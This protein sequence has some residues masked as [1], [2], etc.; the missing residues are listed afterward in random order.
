MKKIRK[1][2]KKFSA[3][4][5]GVTLLASGAAAQNLGDLPQPFVDDD[6][7]LASSIVIGEDAKTSDVVS[8]IDIATTLGNDAYSN[9]TQTVEGGETTSVNGVS[10]ENDI[11]STVSGTLTAT[12]FD[13]LV[14]N[15]EYGENDQ[16]VTEEVRVGQVNG[17]G[18]TVSTT[19]DEEGE[20]RTQVNS[21]AVEYN[22]DYQ[23]GLEQ[24]D[25][26]YLLGTEYELTGVSSDE[27]TLGSTRTTRNLGTGDT[28][29]HGPYTVEVTDNDG[30]DTVYLTIKE[31]GDTI[32]QETFTEGESSDTQSFGDNDEFEV[33]TPS[34]FFGNEERV[35]IETTYSDVTMTDGEEAPVDEDWIVDLG[36]SN[37]DTVD[38][39][40]LYNQVK[41]TAVDKDEEDYND[42]QVA[43]L[44]E[45][46]SLEGPNNFFTVESLGLTEE[47]STQLT[48]KDD[49]E[50]DFTDPNGIEH[51]LDWNNLYNGGSVS[52]GDEGF[53]AVSSDEGKVP[54]QYEVQTLNTGANDDE[55]AAE[56]HFSYG[57]YEETLEITGS[58][59][60]G[61]TVTSSNSGYGFPMSFDTGSETIGYGPG[62][63]YESSLHTEFGTEIAEGVF[64]DANGNEYQASILDSLVDGTITDLDSE[65][66]SSGDYVG[67]QDTNSNYL[68]VEIE[69]FTLGNSG[70]D[71][72]L[73]LESSY[74]QDTP[75]K[76][77]NTIDSAAASSSF[78]SGNY[79]DVTLGESNTDLQ[80]QIDDSGV[81][82]G[83][84]STSTLTTDGNTATSDT[85]NIAVTNTDDSTSQN[86]NFQQVT[87]EK[88][89]GGT[90][91]G[92]VDLGL[93]DTDSDSENELVVTI[94]PGSSN[95]VQA[96]I[97]LGGTGGTVLGEY[98][99][100]SSGTA[101]DVTVDLG[102]DTA[103][104]S[105]S[106]T[107]SSPSV[108][109]TGGATVSATA[110]GDA[111]KTG[112]TGGSGS[113]T[114]SVGQSVSVSTGATEVNDFS[115]NRNGQ[116]F[117]TQINS[118]SDSIQKTY[119]DDFSYTA[120]MISFVN[121]GEI[122]QEFH[123]NDAAAQVTDSDDNTLT[124]SSDVSGDL[125]FDNGNDRFSVS[126]DGD[127]DISSLLL[128]SGTGNSFT[129]SD[130]EDGASSLTTY[131]TSVDLVSEEQATFGIPQNQ[132]QAEHAVGEVSTSQGGD[133]SYNLIDPQGTSEVGVLDSEADTSQDLILVGGPDVNDLTEDLAEQGD[134]WTGDQYT[135]GEGLLQMVSDAFTSGYD[136]LVVAGQTAEDTT[137]AGNFLADYDENLE[138]LEGK[139]QVV[140]DSESGELVEE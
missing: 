5:L 7:E 98:E 19:V 86:Y 1:L 20:V 6:G 100:T 125:S 130:V 59:Y 95:P 71:R 28:V 75:S 84:P 30:E 24:G 139:S 65:Q 56:V 52:E 60:T 31:D 87:V 43:A 102:E 61:S 3:G 117:T 77:F 29:D 25:S 92:S 132:R 39:I 124:S 23:Q 101:S 10:L 83:T 15:Y 17:V 13:N 90:D 37:G 122:K 105:G 99:V 46:E 76:S 53:I 54:V 82:F 35:T 112:N 50:L 108:S 18:N 26:L 63:S 27:I 33:K 9:T 119:S 21:N 118:V 128:D 131:G 114:E 85:G 38:S 81:V 36:T 74:Q 55:T 140:V 41:A 69:T 127:N 103:F 111:S 68:P 129:L 48:V 94:T 8:A 62:A 78:N 96:T 70:N 2:S 12:S 110:S 44:S 109:V 107:T 97:Y 22:A 51:E 45:G 126:Y 47:P 134:T 32:A 133:S 66:Y 64:Q 136:A 73:S 34:V 11:R 137:A 57:G 121:S 80:F 120:D 79:G 49:K 138:D 42:N 89:S 123:F 40:G 58:E 106:S 67:V 135:E 16:R 115:V 91:V 93:S 72:T 14:R 4:L 104:G 116:S 113:A 88:T